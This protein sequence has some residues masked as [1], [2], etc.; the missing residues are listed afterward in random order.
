MTKIK[1]AL[2]LPDE[3]AFGF[4]EPIKEGQ[5]A[6]KNVGELMDREFE[7]S[8]IEGGG[9]PNFHIGQR[10]DEIAKAL[11]CRSCGSNRFFVGK[12]AFFTAIKCVNCEWELCIH[13]G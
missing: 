10:Y 7:P 4:S 13:E 6:G 12:A 11:S 1:G 9:E 2:Y 5:F 8:L 3:G